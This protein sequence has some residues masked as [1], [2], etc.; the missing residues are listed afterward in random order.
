MFDLASPEV[1]MSLALESE[2][3]NV[4]DKHNNFVIK[5]AITWKLRSTKKK[6]F[7]KD[8]SHFASPRQL[9]P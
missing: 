2:F 5:T 9:L 4:K 7:S 1:N 3:S 8:K 6:S